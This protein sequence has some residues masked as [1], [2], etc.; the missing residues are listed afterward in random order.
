VPTAVTLA[1]ASDVTAGRAG[2]CAQ[3]ATGGFCWGANAFGQLGDGTTTDRRAPSAIQNLAA[4]AQPTVGARHACA[5]SGGQ[6]SC[7]G[8]NSLGQLGNGTL[9]MSFA[10][11]EV[12]FP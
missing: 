7:W 1:G 4:D 9:S 11:V 12:A 3:T 8:D 5:L 6:V 10:P 2:T